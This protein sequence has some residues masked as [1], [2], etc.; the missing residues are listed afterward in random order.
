MK[1]L[2]S[3]QATKVPGI[4]GHNDPVF[5]NGVAQY[6]MIG[7]ATPTDVTGMNSGM[8]ARLIQSRSNLRGQTLVDEE[9]HASMPD[10]GARKP[11][12]SRRPPPQRVGPRIGRCSIES[13]LRDVRVVLAKI[14]DRLIALKATQYCIDRQSRAPNDRRSAEDRLIRNEVGV[15]R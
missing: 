7:I 6:D 3:N 1:L 8:S 5:G 9:L 2:F 15:A 4:L 11:R 13:R 14:V 10:G 12:P